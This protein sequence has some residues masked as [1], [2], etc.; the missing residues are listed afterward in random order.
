MWWRQIKETSVW[1]K[2]MA[3]A[4]LITIN[5]TLA[6]KMDPILGDLLDAQ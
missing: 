3:T 2:Y 6:L 5:T 1:L 4:L